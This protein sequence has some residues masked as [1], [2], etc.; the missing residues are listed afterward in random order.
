MTIK[1]NKASF[2]SSPSLKQLLV[3][4]ILM[5]YLN[6]YVVQLYQTCKNLYGKFKVDY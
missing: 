2:I 6:Q 1:Q 3:R 4:V 5:M